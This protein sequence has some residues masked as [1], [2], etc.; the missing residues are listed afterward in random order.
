[1]PVRKTPRG[2]L[3]VVEVDAVKPAPSP[4]PR[5][6]KARDVE[7]AYSVPQ[8]VAKLRRLA[9]AIESGKRFAI[10]VAGERV[11]VPA[12]AVFNIAHEREGDAEEVEFQFTWK[13][14]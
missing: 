9:D 1:M 5:R 14:R 13:R 6:R 8:T 2:A 10:M 12:D 4:R 11:F 7:K 3:A